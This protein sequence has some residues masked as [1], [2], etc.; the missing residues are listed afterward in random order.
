[1]KRLRRKHFDT[2]LLDDAVLALAQGAV[3]PGG[4]RDHALVGN[5]KGV[6]ELH[7]A[8]RGDWLLM[9]VKTETSVILL[10]TGSRDDLFE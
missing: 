1:M 4:W 9:Y 10:R 2:R 8:G 7:V 5:L 6:R 3:L